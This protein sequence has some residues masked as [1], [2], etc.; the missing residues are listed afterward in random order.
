MRSGNHKSEAKEIVRKLGLALL[1]AAL[2]PAAFGAGGAGVA[3]TYSEVWNPPEARATA[4]HKVG[5]AHRLALRRHAVPRGKL[6]NSRR[7]SAPA[8]RLVAKQGKLPRSLRGEEPDMTAIPRQITPE[9]NV[10]RVTGHAA[11][12]GVMR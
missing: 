8:P 9:G 10:L 3:G 4:P 7:T 1:T 5:P 11:S 2:A 6:V 12:V